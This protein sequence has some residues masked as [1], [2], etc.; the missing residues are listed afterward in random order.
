MHEKVP[1]EKERLHKHD[2]KEIINY[3]KFPGRQR[4]TLSQ[5]EIEGTAL[6]EKRHHS[7]IALV[8]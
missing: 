8:L 4:R 5:E 2:E 6:R 1:V 7:S 3:K